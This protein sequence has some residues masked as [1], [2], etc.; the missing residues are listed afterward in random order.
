VFPFLTADP[1]NP[2]QKLQANAFERLE[3][4][5]CN[6]HTPDGT[7]EPLVTPAPSR[8]DG[9]EVTAELL[10]RELVQ[11]SHPGLVFYD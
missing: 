3:L 7:D 2:I 1:V 9:V 10:A 6:I 8:V 11:A 5:I 4:G